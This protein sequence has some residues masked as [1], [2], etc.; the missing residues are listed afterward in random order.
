LELRVELDSN[1]HSRHQVI[2]DEEIGSRELITKKVGFVA[3][4]GND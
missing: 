3:K 1:V 2:R 4:N